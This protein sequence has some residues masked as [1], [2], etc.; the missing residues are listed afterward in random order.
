MKRS[1]FTMIELIFVIVIMGILAAV[2]LP[3]FAGVQD[4]AMIATEKSGIASIRTSIQAIRGHGIVRSSL[5]INQSIFD[6]GGNQYFVWLRKPKSGPE[7]E[8]P[9]YVSRSNY[10]NALS[11]APFT[12]VSG[13]QLVP[14]LNGETG[15]DPKW[16]IST[17][18][19][20]L[21][22]GGRDAWLVGDQTNV[23]ATT[24][25]SATVADNG[26][27]SYLKGPATRNVSD[28]QAEYYDQMWWVYNSYAGTLTVTK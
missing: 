25:A 28:T 1:A 12:G 26:L 2:A 19:V 5:D 20:V 13:A 15:S 21:E 18:A 27:L 17:L 23:G 9:L 7:A 16:G 8:S 24:A 4:D 6:D 22:P 14:Q 3:R 11:T 10:P